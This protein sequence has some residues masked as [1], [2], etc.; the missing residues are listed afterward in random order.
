MKSEE[1]LDR[2]GR[3]SF[4]IAKEFYREMDKRGLSKAV[5]AR[6]IGVDLSNLNQALNGFRFFPVRTLEAAAIVLES[7]FLAGIAKGM[8][9]EKLERWKRKSL[10]ARVVDSPDSIHA[11]ARSKEATA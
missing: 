2:L 4:D 10:H 3:L 6:Q 5:L 9:Q 11:L 1:E 8:R 7:E